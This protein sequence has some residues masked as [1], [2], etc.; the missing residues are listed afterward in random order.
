M[1]YHHQLIITLTNIVTFYK[2]LNHKQHNYIYMH[3]LKKLYII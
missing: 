3:K 1:F 2:Y